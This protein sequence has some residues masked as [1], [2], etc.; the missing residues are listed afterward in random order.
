MPLVWMGK[1]RGEVKSEQTGRS[2]FY[3][4]GMHAMF[5]PTARAP[6]VRGGGL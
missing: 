2:L 3:I 5:R 4:R 6:I 1:K